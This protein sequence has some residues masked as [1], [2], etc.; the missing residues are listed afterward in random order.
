VLYREVA[1]HRKLRNLIKCFWML[2]HDYANSFHD[3]EQ[4]WADAHT[5][6]IFSTGQRYFQKVRSRIVW[7]PANFVIG[8]F[9]HDLQLYSRGRTSFVAARFWPWGFHALSKIPMKA[10]KNT[11]SNC[12]AILG[13]AMESLGAKL[14][15]I[16]RLDARISPL[17][18]ALL[19][20]VETIEAP[21]LHSRPIAKDILAGRGIV[22]TSELARKHRIHPRRMERVFLEEIGVSAKV[23]A[24]IVRF[25]HAKRAIEQKPDIDLLW[26]AHECGYADQSH[27]TRNFREMFGITPSSFKSK[28][29]VLLR[30][31][32]RQRPDV[33]FVQ[34]SAEP[35]E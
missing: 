24:R 18:Q 8:P 3:H 1:P 32:E 28:I 19:N 22:L 25:N 15:P 11:V 13:P 10:L 33:V 34:D 7:T 23:F 6:L 27:F 5:E 20:V 31:F 30:E 9:Q 2:D 4:L 29:Q 12:R 16:E 26:L 17:E 14:A 35:G 21:E